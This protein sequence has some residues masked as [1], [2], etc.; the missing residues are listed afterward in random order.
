MEVTTFSGRDFNTDRGK[1][2]HVLMSIELYRSLTG[3]QKKIA[4]LLAMPGNFDAEFEI[5]AFSHESAKPAD[6]S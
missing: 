2:S 5:P 1:P 6:F 4:D 3:N